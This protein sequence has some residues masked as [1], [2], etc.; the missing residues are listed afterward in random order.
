[1]HFNEKSFI[2]VNKLGVDGA[3]KEIQRLDQDDIAYNEMLQQNWFCKNELPVYFES[4]YLEL[5]LCR[6]FQEKNKKIK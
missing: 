4:D 5:E 2:N 6:A 1:M 3:I